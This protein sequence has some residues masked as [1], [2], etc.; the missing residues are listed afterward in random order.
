MRSW[1]VPQGGRGWSSC[2]TIPRTACLLMRSLPVVDKYFF[3][4]IEA[5]VIA[6]AND[7]ANGVEMSKNE[8]C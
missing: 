8:T 4:C 7:G 3:D 6:S 2:E 5:P 1:E